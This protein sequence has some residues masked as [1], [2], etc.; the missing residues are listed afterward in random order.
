MAF[1]DDDL[2]LYYHHSVIHTSVIIPKGKFQDLLSRLEAAEAVIKARD[3]HDAFDCIHD[4][5]NQCRCGSAERE[6]WREYEDADLAWRK[7]AGK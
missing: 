6:L 1:T 5:E 3:A 4:A 7:A 2:K